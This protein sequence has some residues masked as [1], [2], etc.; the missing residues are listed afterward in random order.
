MNEALRNALAASGLTQLDIAAHLSVDPKTVEKWLAGRA[1]HPRTRITLAKLLGRAENDL[2]PKR[3]LPK[4]SEGATGEI[5]AVYP[6]QWAVPRYVWLEVF[7]QAEKCIDILDY[8]ALFL[9][10]DT[11]I[12]SLLTQ[13]ADSN[14]NIRLL[15]RDPDYHEIVERGIDERI[16]SMHANRIHNALSLL[17]RLVE[18]P[19]VQTRLYGTT[20]Y[21][22]LYRG[23]SELLVNTHIYGVAALAAPVLHLNAAGQ[24]GASANYFESF[25]KVWA[26]AKTYSPKP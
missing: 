8:S 23:D 11:G 4:R 18:H 14:V 22:S 10:E 25:E 24:S 26:S 6:H 13:K 21:N 5:R 19:S 2:W 17:R 1:P 15:L 20:I 9:A 12:T 16:R 3:S 7:Q